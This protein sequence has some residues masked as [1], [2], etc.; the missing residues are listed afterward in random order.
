[1]SGYYTAT[2]NQGDC[3]GLNLD[4]ADCAFAIAGFAAGLLALLFLLICCSQ[5]PKTNRY[6]VEW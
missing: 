6:V 4:V 5:V 3:I 2:D 1:M